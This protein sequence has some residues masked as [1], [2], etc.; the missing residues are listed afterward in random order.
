MAVFLVVAILSVG[1][2]FLRLHT[3]GASSAAFDGM[4]DI[5]QII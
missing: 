3:S 1:A 2:L 5:P 4:F